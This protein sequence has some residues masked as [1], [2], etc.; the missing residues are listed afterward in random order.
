[1]SKSSCHFF[2]QSSQVRDGED[3]QPHNGNKKGTLLPL[4]ETSEILIGSSRCGVMSHPSLGKLS[5]GLDVS[6]K[7]KE[8]SGLGLRLWL[9]GG[10]IR[11]VW[12]PRLACREKSRGHHGDTRLDSGGRR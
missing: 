5:K 8:V 7:P 4:Q 1:M 11:R 3:L 12:T 9:R 6:S 10:A 2:H